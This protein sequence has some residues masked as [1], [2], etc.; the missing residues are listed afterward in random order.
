VSRRLAAAA[1]LALLLSGCGLFGGDRPGDAARAFLAAWAGG[2]LAR[3]GQATDSP[4]AAQALLQRVRQTLRPAGLQLD[5]GAV[6]RS[7]DTTTA[8]FHASVTLPGVVG[9]WRYDGSLALARSG[10]G[11]TVHWRPADVHPALDDGQSLAAQR[12]LPERAPILDRAGQPLFRPTPVVTVGIQRS[13]VKDLAGLA[14]TLAAHLPE[15]TA[16]EVVAAVRRARPD[17]LVPVIT[18][19][20]PDYLKVR[21]VIYP[22]PGTVFRAGTRVLGPTAHFGQPM[23]GRVGEATAEVLEEAGGR[24]LAGDQLGLSGLQRVMNPQ[25]TGTASATVSV[26]DGQGRVVGKVGQLTGTAGTPVRTTLD[27]AVQRAAEAALATVPGSGAIVA[28]KP[29]TG[30]ILA[31]ADSVGAPFDL[32]LAGQYPAGS[33]FKIITV[34]AVLASHVAKPADTLP[35]PGTRTVGGRVFHNDDSFDLGPVSLAQ[36]F[37]HSCNTTFTLLAPRLP[38]GA[39]VATAAAYGIGAGWALP[40]PSFSGSLPPPGGDVELAADAIGQGKVLVSPFAM[41]EV[42]ATLRHG[43]PLPPSLLAGQLARPGTT[44]TTALDPATLATVRGFARAVVTSGTA[45][46]LR[47]LPGAV[48]GKTGTA[49]YGTATPPRSHAWFVGY[50]GDLA[51][52]VFIQD[53]GSSRT[54]AVPVAR[55]FLSAAP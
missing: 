42:A 47:D 7:G 19:R 51:F 12:T 48:A 32:A 1:V 24:Y 18:L 17:E 41:A 16:A 40:V 43:S 55:A 4:G 27:P 15:V 46:L 21:S 50:R 5:V 22:L 53:G 2:D 33:T 23:L 20:R 30:E 52:A 8:A 38:A 36:A 31:V 45:G 54:T 29:S 3:A 6:R 35:C 34:T 44:P 25:L 13:R 26:V 37:A 9:P 11:W 14:R 49:E 28:V 39:L 10:A